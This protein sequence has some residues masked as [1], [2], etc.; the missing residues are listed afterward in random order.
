MAFVDRTYF[1]TGELYLPGLDKQAIQ[2]KIDYFISI[3][4]PDCLKKLLGYELWKLFTDGLLEDSPAQKWLDLRDGVEFTGY[5][6]RVKRWMG[7][8]GS[9]DA[10]PITNVQAKN[11]LEVQVDITTGFTS[12][13]TTVTFDGTAGKPDFR[14]YKIK[15]ER[16]GTGT[17]WSSDFSFNSTT[18]KWD[19]LNTG[20][21]FQ[22]LEKFNVRFEP[23]AVVINPG[24][25]INLKQS[26]IANYVYYWFMREAASTTTGIG[27]TSPQGENSIN[28]TPA[29]KMQRAWVEMMGWVREFQ[30][31]MNQK[32]EDYPEFF[33]H[34]IPAMFF[35]TVNSFGI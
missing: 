10:V 34:N 31:F 24:T 27:E 17:M 14:G 1:A 25:A 20:D 12:N 32:R 28:A 3:H 26:I 30:E 2:E 29:Y 4:E 22:P 15:P 33:Y 7:F 19:L 35:R 13:T 8:T 5:N 21:K 16:I 6:G 11:E 18:G 23:L 9:A